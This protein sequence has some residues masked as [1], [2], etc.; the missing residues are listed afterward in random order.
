LCHLDYL[1]TDNNTIERRNSYCVNANCIE[2]AT[3]VDQEILHLSSQSQYN[4]T[5]DANDFKECKMLWFAA[6]YE[7]EQLREDGIFHKYNADYS[8]ALNSVLEHACDT[9]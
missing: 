7:S 6:T 2:H 8:V 3:D 9:I 1:D 4:N 5:T